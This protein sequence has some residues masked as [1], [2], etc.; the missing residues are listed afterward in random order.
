MVNK[1]P[2]DTNNCTVTWIFHIVVQN[3]RCWGWKKNCYDIEPL[4]TKNLLK[5]NSKDSVFTA[6]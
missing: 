6:Q 4:K 1:Y 5:F 2:D 3:V